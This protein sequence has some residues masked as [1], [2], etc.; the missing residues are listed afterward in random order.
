MPGCAD[1]MWEDLSDARHTINIRRMTVKGS[2]YDSRMQSTQP[3]RLARGVVEEIVDRV[4]TGRFVPGQLIPIEGEL[5]AEFGVS[6][7]V[8]REAI[9][10]LEGM[11]LVRAQ[12][13]HGTRIRPE[14]EWDLMNPTVLN[15][16]VQHDAEQSFL[17]HVVDVRRAL[18]SQMAEQAAAVADDELAARLEERWS[19]LAEAEDDPPE[20]VRRDFAFHDAIHVASGNRLARAAIRTLTQEASRSVR[21]VGDPSSA[22]CRR[23]NAEHRAVLDAV[24]ARDGIA[25]RALMDAHVLDAWLRRRPHGVR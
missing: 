11:R 20:F 15:A 24:V 13:G 25:A 22:E 8:L 7:A 6:R 21:Y 12:Q 10:E 17:D 1:E 16:C 14:A 9:K 23:S 18:E 5:T 2:I 19:A 3:R 4:I